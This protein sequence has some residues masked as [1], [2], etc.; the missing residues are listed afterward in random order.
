MITTD[1]ATW[2]SSDLQELINLKIEE[3]QE[4]EYK[5][6]RALSE[7]D[8]SNKNWA[9]EIS[10]D[11]SAMANST[12][13]IIIYG[14]QEK[15]HL[16]TKINGVNPRSTTKEWLEQ[17]ITSNIQRKIEGLR[18]TPISVSDS[19]TAYVVNVPVSPRAPHQAKDGRFY[20]RNNFTISIMQ[21]YEIRDIANRKGKPD[22]QIHCELRGLDGSQ[23]NRIGVDVRNNIDLE[24]VGLVSNKESAP[25]NYAIFKFYVPA[26]LRIIFSPEC[27]KLDDE[28]LDSPNGEIPMKV[29]QKS[30]HVAHHLPIWKGN[31]Y[32][33]FD[34]QSTFRV[35]PRVDF[36]SWI[37]VDVC[38]P[39]TIETETWFNIKYVW[40]DSEITI[41]DKQY[42]HHK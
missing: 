31:T 2:T 32:R 14:I 18:I 42:L 25:A 34:S 23:G 37:K 1:P 38:S 12:G 26:F 22:L 13:G 20:K 28:T 7:R 10:K 17:V 11:V 39:E 33:I 35:S 36:D 15:N 3:H 4:L 8:N 29:W 9:V 5:D 21:E 40:M 27:T 19:E 16:P 30:W 24:L 41:E 6:G